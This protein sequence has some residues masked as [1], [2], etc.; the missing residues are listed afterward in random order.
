MGFVAGTLGRGGAE[1]QLIYMLKALQ[2]EGVNTR[3]LC[4]TKGEALEKEILDLGISVDWVGSSK[5]NLVRL[6]KIISNLR[7]EAVDIIQSSHFYTNTYAALGGRGLGIPNVG[8][9][10]GDLNDAIASNGLFGNLQ[11]KFPRHLI[12][13]S[14]SAVGEATARGI[15]QKN[16]DLVR[17]AVDFSNAIA[18]ENKS[19]R[20]RLNILFAG[21]L[22]P[23]KRPEI[24]LRMASELHRG[25]FDHDLN[26]QLAGDGPLRSQLEKQAVEF[27][28]P[29]NYIS[30]LGEQAEMNKV[31]METD[32][33]V[34]TS[35]HE[36]T[37]NVILE[38]MSHGIP[39]VAT[40]VGGVPEILGKEC[41]MLVE[42]DDPEEIV[43]AVRTL[44]LDRDLRCRMGGHA[45]EYVRK[46]HSF[47]YLQDRLTGIYS[48]IL[49]KK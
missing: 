37:P 3:V 25:G 30:F 12:A 47:E 45:R 33:L 17:N 44:I 39:V 43:K 9:I 49:A 11:L 4:L 24:F 28:L 5:N 38:A 34:L 35:E 36:G 6:N 29:S 42:P 20:D 32:I 15:D 14:R 22:V 16:I 26:F 48:Q 7:S 13:N 8:A 23:V 31:Y 27:G 18:K 41:G 1:R 10:R 2:N 21:R 40:R 19:D 46:N